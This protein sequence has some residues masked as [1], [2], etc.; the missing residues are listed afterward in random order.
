LHDIA[1]SLDPIETHLTQNQIRKTPRQR[2]NAQQGSSEVSF[3]VDFSI[4]TRLH[5]RGTH[6]IRPVQEMIQFDPHKVRIFSR[7]G[8]QTQFQNA[9]PVK[10][11]SEDK[12]EWI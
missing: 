10:T 2:L 1:E 6:W 7:Q 5:G 12:S 4:P 8:K 9:I 3:K 11:F